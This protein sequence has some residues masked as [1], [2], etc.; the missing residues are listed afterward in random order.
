MRILLVEDEDKVARFIQI[1]LKAERFGRRMNRRSLRVQLITWFAALL[2]AVMLSFGAYTYLRV[3]NY[4]AEVLGASMTHR[5]EQIART[6]LANIAKTGDQYVST[7]I[8]TRYAP[9]LNDRFIRITRPDGSILYRSSEPNDHSFT[10]QSVPPLTAKLTAPHVRKE[11]LP[12]EE[13]MLIASVPY[14]TSQGTYIVE[15]GASL[16]GSYHVLHKLLWTLAAGLLSV[17][18]LTIFG[19]W[20]LIKRALTPVQN[21][22]LAAQD[23]TLHHLSRRLPVPNTGDE[24]AS[25][26]LVLNRMIARLDES[27]QQTS[28]FTSDASHELRT[29][30]TIMRG[31]LEALL[32][33]RELNAEIRDALA[34]LLEE[35][36][37]LVRIVEGLFAMSR[38]D[39][40]EAQVERVKLDL[41]SLVETTAEQMCLLAEEKHIT[42]KCE[43][44]ERAEVEGDRA[45]LKQ[46]VVNL[47]DN[48]IKYTPANGN[49][50][51]TVRTQS[52]TIL[53]EVI[54]DGPGVPEAAL[55]HVFKRFY[56]ADEVHSRNVDGA[57]LGLSIVQSICA[58][59]GGSVTIK[60]E[61]RGGCRVTVSLP[62]AH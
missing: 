42:L 47:L 50:A 2:M 58:A 19:G 45:R 26:S 32:S 33:R 43:T 25:L 14:P 55:P 8:E 4:V 22:M 10:P 44:R 21:I 5:A 3:Q 57:G 7:E 34:S 31:E 1:G 49:I 24:I 56:R 48:A 46:V 28:R 41:A 36:E 39:T 18:T 20:M 35:L 11:S 17:L 61:S 9:A 6:L 38:L 62:R 30:L 23:I 27:F 52:S 60:N 37:R 59:H 53:F 51:L 13:K 15:A 40:G 16:A 54:D 29:P 12:N